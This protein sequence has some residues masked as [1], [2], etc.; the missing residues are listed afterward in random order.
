MSASQPDPAA[1]GRRSLMDRI[2]RFAVIHGSRRRA[3]AGLSAVSV[4]DFFVPALPTQSS[5][6]ALGVMQPQRAAWIALVA[7]GGHMDH[8]TFLKNHGDVVLT[9]LEGTGLVVVAAIG[10]RPAVGIP[11]LVRRT[12]GIGQRPVTR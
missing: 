10:G 9:M 5:V 7:S 4:G 11:G 2:A 3:I 12:L 1:S 6:L 8:D